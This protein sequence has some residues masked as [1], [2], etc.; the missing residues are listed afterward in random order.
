MHKRLLQTRAKS[1]NILVLI[2]WD[3]V[4]IWFRDS[5]LSF[6]HVLSPSR[7]TAAGIFLT[8]IQKQR[9]RSWMYYSTKRRIWK[10]ITRIVL[11]FFWSLNQIICKK[12]HGFRRSKNSLDLFFSIHFS[13]HYWKPIR[14]NSPIGD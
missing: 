4:I 13:K 14:N 6:P 1:Q 8:E 12:L 2:T 11:L 10:E 9:Q 3:E 7:V 5:V